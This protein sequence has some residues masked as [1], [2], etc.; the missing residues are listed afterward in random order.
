MQVRASREDRLLVAVING[1]VAH[2]A[3]SGTP[4]DAAV[5]VVLDSATE[6]AVK[7][8]P[9]R[10]G[11]RARLRVDLLTDVAGTF[12]G[13]RSWWAPAAH[14]LTVEAIKAA[15]HVPDWDAIRA[16]AVEAAAASDPQPGGIGSPPRPSMPED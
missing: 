1:T 7:S 9:K 15:G 6:P 2:E 12:L 16:R 14:Q 5:A 8:T 3:C 10:P 13:A 4:V 11:R